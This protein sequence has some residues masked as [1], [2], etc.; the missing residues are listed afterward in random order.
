MRHLAAFLLALALVVTGGPAWVSLAVPAALAQA[1]QTPDYAAWEK[2]AANAEQVLQSDRASNS[3]LDEM[4]ARFVD[5][6]AQFLSA[7]STNASQIET[8][9]A[10]IAA[11]GPAPADGKSESADIAARRGALGDQLATLQ[12]PG[13]KAVEAYSRADGIIRQID[14]SVRSRQ[15]SEL[16][17]LWPSPLNPVNWPAGFAVL[18]QG[19]KTLW[20][21]TTEAWSNPIH[22]TQLKNNLPV[23]LLL[24][25]LA[26]LLMIKGPT[27]MERLTARLQR[28]ASM[29]ARGL[30]A[31]VVSV[32]QVAVPVVGMVLLLLAIIASGMAGTRARALFAAL[33]PA[34]FA[35]FFARWVASQIFD[36]DGGPAV[37]RTEARF[38]IMMIGLLYALEEFRQAFTSEVR[39]PLS[40]AAQSVWGAPLVCVVAIFSFRLGQILRAIGRG[41][42]DPEVQQQFRNRMLR[43]IGTALVVVSAV[44]PALALVGYVNA[45]NGLIW[46]AVESI[47]LLGLLVLLQRF[48]TDIYVVLTG[49]GAAGREALIPVLI[50]ALLSVIALPFLALIWGARTA[51]L[52][53]LWTRFS[54]GIP[55]GATRLSPTIILTLVIVFAL[56]YMLTKLVQGALTSSILPRTRLDKGVQHAVAAGVGYV[57]HFLAALVAITTAGIDLSALAYVAGALSVGI[58][59]GLQN[60]V[61]NFVSGIILLIERP[62]SEGDMIE[63]NGQFGIVKGISVRSTWIET[64]DRT[65][66]I[67]PNADLVSGVVTNLTRGNLTGRLILPVGVAYGTDTRKVEAILREIAEGE[68]V[69]L[70]SPPPTVAFVG[71]GAD[72]LNFEIR[73]ILS[74]VNFKLSVQTEILHKITERFAAEGI[75]IPFAQRDIWVRNAEELRPGA[76]ARRKPAAREAPADNEAPVDPAQVHNDPEADEADET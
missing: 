44:A 25:A 62:I 36:R 3:A 2:D 11:L 40:L 48:G 22:R 73:A 21:E 43:L 38:H 37:N 75:E 33:P 15:A 29:R 20:A 45:A 24:T 7:Q 76:R 61:Q 42:G 49:S 60:I 64:F 14:A 4:R 65:D 8:L 63:V 1:A 6:R 17:K 10:Q 26:A 28:G 51:D 27:V 50:G 35:F 19:I 5:W 59:F 23:I 56:G 46:P 55:I 34:A 68:P 41:A 9:K 12:A 71:F 67:V 16:L 32:G 30:A 13:L 39:P 18:N 31:G 66:V 72:S 69:V 53:E 57:G 58:G 54:E 70:V 52:S 47:G 74:D